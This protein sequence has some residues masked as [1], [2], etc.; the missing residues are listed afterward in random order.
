M[1][2]LLSV[3]DREGVEALAR[4][5]LELGVEIYATDGTREHLAANGV[6]VE[7]VSAL[8]NAPPL[9]GGQVKT[10]H[11]AVYAGI[12]ARRNDGEELAELDQHGIGLID[13]V[14]VNVKPFAPQ[15]GARTVPLDE[16]ISMID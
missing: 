2:A 8:T 12:L 4:Q 13:L 11:P 15:V 1:R 9:V 7:P 16:A 14:V 10:F 5:L 6:E 3:A